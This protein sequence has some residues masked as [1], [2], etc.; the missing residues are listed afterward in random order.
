MMHNYTCHASIR[1]CARLWTDIGAH[2]RTA[3]FIQAI[4]K[5]NAAVNQTGYIP[6]LASGV[7]NLTRPTPDKPKGMSG[8]S[9][10]SIKLLKPADDAGSGGG[11]PGVL[12]ALLVTALES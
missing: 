1:D 4:N 3:K 9:V 7:P 10:G 5:A 12:H 8:G 6:T 11:N 2:R